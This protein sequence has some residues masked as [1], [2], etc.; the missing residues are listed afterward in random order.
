ML[1]VLPH[2]PVD[3]SDEELARDWTL[4]VADLEEV[5]KSRGAEHRQRFA[6]QLCA[7]RAIG[8]F[9]GDVAEIPVRIANHIG[10]Q[11]GLPPALFIDEPARPATVSEQAQRIREYLG[12]RS[13]D[14]GA[15]HELQRWHR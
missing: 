5:R 6:V 15:Q 12:Y 1:D 3:P 13:F 9:V 14:N 8:R 7:L 10:R 11:L 4:S 2:L